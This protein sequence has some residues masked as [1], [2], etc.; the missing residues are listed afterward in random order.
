VYES[1]WIKEEFKKAQRIHGELW[2]YFHEHG[3]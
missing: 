1:A 3:D 2:T